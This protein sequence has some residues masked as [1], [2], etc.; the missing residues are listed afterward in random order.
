MVEAE[1]LGGLEIDD[2]LDFRGLLDRQVGG[3][4]ALQNAA[5]IRRP[6]DGARPEDWPITHQTSGRGELTK[7]KDCRDFMAQCQGGELFGV[8][9][10]QRVIANHQRTGTQLAQGSKCLFEVVGRTCVQDMIRK[11]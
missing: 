7:L 2:Q 9:S 10:E 11:P 5:G 8:T 4:F 1:R 6:P 3:L